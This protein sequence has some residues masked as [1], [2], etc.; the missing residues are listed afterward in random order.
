MR[1][2]FDNCLSP[3]LP[4]VLKAAG[5]GKKLEIIHLTDRFDAATPDYEWIAALGKE[6]GWIIVSGDERIRSAKVNKEAWRESG[7]TS[8][9]FVSPFQTSQRVKQCE[10]LLRWW[11]EILFHARRFPSGHGF[12]LPMRGK[13]AQK[14]YP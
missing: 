6:G 4:A 11:P 8:F 13:D 9:F 5:E 14:V 12:R 7:L 3:Q 1:F 2:F 10:E